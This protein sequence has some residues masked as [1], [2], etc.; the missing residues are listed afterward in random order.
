MASSG[1][2]TLATSGALTIAATGIVSV[3]GAAN[4]NVNSATQINLSGS[5]GQLRVG[6]SS[7]SH[8][9]AK[10]DAVASAF[11]GHT[12]SGVQSGGGTTSGPSSSM[13]T[14][15]NSTAASVNT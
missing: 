15:I 12:H 11:D 4:V 3:N 10:A 2:M 1:A 13:G 5:A 8:A 14:G 9:L 6:G 7:L